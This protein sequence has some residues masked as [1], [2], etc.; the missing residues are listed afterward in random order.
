M[1]SWTIK[2]DEHRRFDP[3]EL[4]CWR[5]LLR[6]LGLQGDQTSQSLRKSVL[7]IHWKDWCWSWNSNNLATWCEELTHWKDPDAG[8]DWRQEEKGMKEDEMVGWHLQLDG[9]VFGQTL[10]VG[11]GQGS[12]VCCGS[13]G[14]RESDTTEWLNWTEDSSL[15][16]STSDSSEVRGGARIYRSFTTKGRWS[17]TSKDYC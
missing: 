3:F 2:K 5:R 4:W 9:H 10:G 15:G 13:W 14:H 11:D 7:N 8:K 12:L 17:G 1:R 16:D 6:S